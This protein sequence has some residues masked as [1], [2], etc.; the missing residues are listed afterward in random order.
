M[1]HLSFSWGPESYEEGPT[2]ELPERSGIG[3]FNLSF[4]VI[5]EDVY[6]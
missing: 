2:V 5:P 1:N 6:L 3:D 4:V